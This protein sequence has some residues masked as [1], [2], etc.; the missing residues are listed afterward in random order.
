MF[1]IPFIED[2]VT[3]FVLSPKEEAELIYIPV[4]CFITA[5]G[6]VRTITTSQTV[7]DYSRKKYGIDLYYYSDTDSISCGLTD[8]DLEELKDIIKI[9]DFKIGYWKKEGTFDR[10]V[11]IRQKCYI[12]EINGKVCPT[13]AGMPKYLSPLVTFENFKRGFTTEGMS[14]NDMIKEA[15]KNGASTEEI[16]KIHHKLTYKYVKGG[17]ILADTDFTI[18]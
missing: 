5:Y 16:E 8:E 15:L 14:M 11:F 12:K 18:K 6:R 2:G 1:K 13:V 3:K 4:A 17:V 9:D 10:A 7:S